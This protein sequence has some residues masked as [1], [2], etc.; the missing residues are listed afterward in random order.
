MFC[1]FCGSRIPDG[2][3]ECPSCG[4]KM[5]SNRRQNSSSRGGGRYSAKK[6][7]RGF[8]RIFRNLLLIVVAVV[9]VFIAFM[10]FADTPDYV[11]IV[12]NGHLGTYTDM[13]VR[14][15]LEVSKWGYEQT[16]DSGVTNDGKELVE[17]KFSSPGEEPTTIQFI[18]LDD[19]VFKLSAYVDPKLPIEKST[20]LLFYINSLYYAEKLP[21]AMESEFK[22]ADL[23]SLMKTTPANAVM[24][25]ASH[26]YTGD[27]AH[28]FKLFGEDELEVSV[29]D[30]MD[31]YGAGVNELFYGGDSLDSY[32][33]DLSKVFGDVEPQETVQSTQP[34]IPNIPDVSKCKSYTV[35]ELLQEL[36]QNALRAERKYQGQ[37]ILLT[38]KICGFES[39]GEYFLLGEI[40]DDSYSPGISCYIKSEKILDILLEKNEGDPLTIQCMV[41]RVHE[42]YQYSVDVLSIVESTLTTPV[43]PEYQ[44]S[45]QTSD[46]P[47]FGS[48]LRSAGEIRIRSG[49]STSYADIGR[50]KG[51]TQVTIY[52]QQQEAS[53]RWWGRMDDGWV[54]MD[55]I[56]FGE[57]T[58][59]A[60]PN[61]NSGVS[62]SNSIVGIY[63]G[64]S[65]SVKIGYN[66]YN[67]SYFAQ[68]E[69]IRLASFELDGYFDTNSRVLYLSG[70]DVVICDEWSSIDIALTFDINANNMT[71]AVEHSTNGMLPVGYSE[72]YTR[73]R[74]E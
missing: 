22:Q 39:N 71:L 14:E 55:Y 19:A 8:G 38:G 64:D 21:E 65:G 12:K 20:D 26:D 49:P 13:T 54:C 47:Q 72:V 51:G 25:G 9:I 30:L 28:L 2:T 37:Y 27:R 59:V 4:S 40:S 60:P 67:G 1:Q 33:V 74:N 56:V 52:E 34:D 29:Y 16:W 69:I 43:K 50:L 7:K 42:D 61:F 23:L 35:D 31:V 15:M 17:V 63:G 24:Y 73:A 68:I 6:P 46:N 36:G 41:T 45:I 62:G 32:D 70:K 48:V 5:N 53:G 18:M 66:D 57:D 3:V 44:E 10:L 11:S 58:S